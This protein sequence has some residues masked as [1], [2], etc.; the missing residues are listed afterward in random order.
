MRGWL[1]PLRIAFRNS[2]SPY[3]K[4]TASLALDSYVSNSPLA[5]VYP[6]KISSTTI[7]SVLQILACGALFAACGYIPHVDS[8]H[9]ANF[10][11]DSQLFQR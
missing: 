9:K 1:H 11:L 5:F 10:P 3:K 2:R 6:K 4:G 8:T 7:Q